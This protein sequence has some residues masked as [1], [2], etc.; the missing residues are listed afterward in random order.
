MHSKFCSRTNAF[1]LFSCCINLHASL[2]ILCH[3]VLEEESKCLVFQS[4]I[5]YSQL[6]RNYFLLA[7]VT[8]ASRPTS[9]IPVTT[10]RPI[11]TT[12]DR[13]PSSRKA[14]QKVPTCVLAIVNCCSRYDE[15]VRTP[16]FEKYNCV[17]AFFGKSPCSPDIKAAAF[18]EVE[19]FSR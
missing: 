1:K 8:A 16:C 7:E 13:T 19:K 6:C 11:I 17:G 18:R 12:P 4:R 14:N 15:I 9:V 2:F 3:C 5:K 10:T